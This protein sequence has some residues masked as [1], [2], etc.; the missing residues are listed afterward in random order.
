VRAES[1]R[2]HFLQAKS[3]SSC[4]SRLEFHVGIP[5]SSLLLIPL[6]YDGIRELIKGYYRILKN[7]TYANV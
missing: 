7:S 1:D 5:R 2:L 4:L 6:R 3:E